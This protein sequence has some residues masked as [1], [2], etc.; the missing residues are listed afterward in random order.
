M[1][2]KNVNL[3]VEILAEEGIQNPVILANVYLYSSIDKFNLEKLSYGNEFPEIGYPWCTGI[4][5]VERTGDAY[6]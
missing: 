6:K 1:I 2:Q 3:N 5:F 4:F